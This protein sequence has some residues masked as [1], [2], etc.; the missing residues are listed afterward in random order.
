MKRGYNETMTLNEM[1]QENDVEEN[2]DLRTYCTLIAED[3]KE[4]TSEGRQ[5]LREARPF[6]RTLPWLPTPA[7]VRCWLNAA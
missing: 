4:L 5:K 1:I 2:D 6:A 7:L 3:C